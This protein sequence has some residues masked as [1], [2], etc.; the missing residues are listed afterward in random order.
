MS[1]C[2]IRQDSEP[3]MSNKGLLDIDDKARLVAPGV[4]GVWA[5]LEAAAETVDTRVPVCN[6][7]PL[8]ETGFPWDFPLRILFPQLGTPVGS[9]LPDHLL[10]LW[11]LGVAST[12]LDQLVNIISW[13]LFVIGIDVGGV[14]VFGAFV[15]MWGSQR[16]TPKKRHFC[17]RSRSSLV[18][19][20]AQSVALNLGWP[21]W[22]FRYEKDFSKLLKLVNPLQYSKEAVSNQK[23]VD[24]SVI[25]RIRLLKITKKSDYFGGIQKLKYKFSHIFRKCEDLHTDNLYSAEKAPIRIEN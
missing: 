19:A 13:Q 14:Q 12:D 8:V 6:L 3:I 10:Q 17:C 4:N 9:C 2:K 1:V 24:K 21:R 22:N 20:T 25:Y 11:P 23:W 15:T 7:L 5:F 16:H 18:E